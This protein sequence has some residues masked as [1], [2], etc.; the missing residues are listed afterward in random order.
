MILSSVHI[1][2]VEI[3]EETYTTITTSTITRE[4]WIGDGVVE[5][6]TFDYNERGEQE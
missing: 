1:D 3:E 6:E 5:K 2:K 4:M